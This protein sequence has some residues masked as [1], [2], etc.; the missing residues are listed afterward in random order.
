MI[1]KMDNASLSHEHC[2]IRLSERR[3]PG[4]VQHL[5]TSEIYASQEYLG[6]GAMGPAPRQR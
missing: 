3:A 6:N 5:R 1:G 4:L 2:R